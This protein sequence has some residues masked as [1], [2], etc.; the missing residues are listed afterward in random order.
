VHV[1]YLDIEWAIEHCTKGA[2]IWA[3]ASRPV[4]F[5]FHAF[6]WLIH[7]LTYYRPH[8][9]HILMRAYK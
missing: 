2:G 7:R 3:W 8:Q 1:H 9:D 5:N 4:I 6:P